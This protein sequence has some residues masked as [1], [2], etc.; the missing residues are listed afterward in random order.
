MAKPTSAR[1]ELMARCCHSSPLAERVQN[2]FN[3][4]G[5]GSVDS[6]PT[7]EASC[8]TMTVPGSSGGEA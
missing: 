8:Q 2:A 5:E 1:H 7:D 6:Q 4:S 3:P